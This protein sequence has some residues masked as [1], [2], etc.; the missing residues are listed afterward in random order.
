MSFQNIL[1]PTDGSEA[2]KT[3]V[4]EAF[5]LAKVAGG[6]ITALFVKDKNGT[7]EMA[8]AAVGY[9]AEQGKAN[10]IPVETKVLQGQPAETIAKLAADYDVIVMGTL[11]RTGMKKLFAGSVAEKVVKLSTIPVIVVRNSEKS[12]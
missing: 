4:A 8:N 3:A 2:V 11:G 7:D 10:G 12:Q 6:H 5:E 9:V 1:V